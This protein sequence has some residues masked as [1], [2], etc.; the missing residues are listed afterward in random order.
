MQFHFSGCIA[1]QLILSA[2]TLSSPLQLPP[3]AS[4][5]QPSNTSSSLNSTLSTINWYD[6]PY[7][8]RIPNTAVTIIYSN[9]AEH[10]YGINECWE[11]ATEDLSSDHAR[12]LPPLRDTPMGTQERAYS[13]GSH[14]P[15]AHFY[16]NPGPQMT[17]GHCYNMM[18]NIRF[19][20]R[21]QDGRNL[22]GAGFMFR[23][24]VDG[25]GQVGYG[26]FNEL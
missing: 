12:H 10:N 7:S 1:P 24:E 25:L 4:L 18:S 13:G 6:D 21:G 11:K 16:I 23:V 8:Y 26:M 15:D 3:V 22:Y 9:Y 5:Y 20:V 19:I 14:H 2:V 17:W